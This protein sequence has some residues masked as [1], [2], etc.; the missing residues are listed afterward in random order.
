MSSS[1]IPNGIQKLLTYATVEK[2]D[3]IDGISE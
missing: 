2:A 3:R 1:K